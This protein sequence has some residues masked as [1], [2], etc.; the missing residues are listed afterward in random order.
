MTIVD[1]APMKV[2][3]GITDIG[4]LSPK[5]YIYQTPK[6]IPAKVFHPGVILKAE[7]MIPL[8]MNTFDVAIKTG[9]QANTLRRIIKAKAGVSIDVAVKLANGFETTPEFWLNLQNSYDCH[10]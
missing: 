7:F 2:E 8:Q 3:L 4:V 6:F 5:L 10:K 9:I 1:A